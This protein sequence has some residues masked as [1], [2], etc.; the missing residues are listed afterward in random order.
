MEKTFET[1]KTFEEVWTVDVIRGI[2]EDYKVYS[3]VY[4][5]FASKVFK[6]IWSLYSLRIE[7]QKLASKF[8][9]T[10]I[11]LKKVFNGINTASTC[12]FY[13]N[14]CKAQRILFL[15]SEIKRLSK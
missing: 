3:S 5:C 15:E 4:L 11:S 10:D 7:L 9:P 6:E 8:D 13:D 14:S 2:L 1:I 12:L